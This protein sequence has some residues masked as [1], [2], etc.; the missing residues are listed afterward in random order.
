MAMLESRAMIKVATATE[1]SFK[2]LTKSNITF[3][4]CMDTPG[5]N[6]SVNL[7]DIR[8]GVCRAVVVRKEEAFIIKGD[9]DRVSRVIVNWL[10]L[11]VVH[12]LTSLQPWRVLLECC[13]CTINEPIKQ[14]VCMPI[15]MK[16]SYAFVKR[17][18]QKRKD[19]H[20]SKKTISKS[21]IIKWHKRQVLLLTVDIKIW[22]TNH[23]CLQIERAKSNF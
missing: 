4:T 21:I 8:F 23:E 18:V 20:V 10:H 14:I 3:V 11:D 22:S 13:S 9:D 19:L 6:K 17:L 2:C 1:V 15:L 5:P 7:L 12:F 16:L